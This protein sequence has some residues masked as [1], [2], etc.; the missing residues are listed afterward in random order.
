LRNPQR[1]TGVDDVGFVVASAY[2]SVIRA[3]RFDPEVEP[4]GV[5]FQVNAYTSG[6]QTRQPAVALDQAGQFVVF[7]T[8][9]TFQ[10]EGDL[11][12]RLFDASG[13]PSSGEFLVN[14][15]TVG[16][17]GDASAALGAGGRLQVV[18]TSYRQDGDAHGI[19]ARRFDASGSALAT[20]L[21]VNVR[22]LGR[23]S[24]PKIAAV[25]DAG[26]VVVWTDGQ[27][28]TTT[29]VGRLLDPTGVPVGGEFQ[30]DPTPL[31]RQTS[32]RVS[33][34]D[35]G[36]FVVSW[37]S[38]REGDV[39]LSVFARRFQIVDAAAPYEVP[40][41]TSAVL[42]ILASILAAGGWLLLRR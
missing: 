32:P 4:I 15:H 27:L 7:W 42:A 6:V 13:A 10:L 21:Q 1:S 31:F 25:G 5:Q 14:A 34:R 28:L 33:A 17:Q 22:T 36:R 35:D 30:I 18:W 29:V 12:A 2:G 11:F 37:N 19:F 40:A 41:L 38:A 26:F 16:D 8:R 24:V 23:Q 9:H 39:S 3:S 20:E